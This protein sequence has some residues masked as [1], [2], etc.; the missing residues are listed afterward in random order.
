MT[1]PSDLIFALDTGTRTVTGLV[2]DDSGP[3]PVVLGAVTE[4][5][6]SRAMMDGQIHDI[7]AVAAV[8][9]T[10]KE[11]LER[12]V[13]VTLEEAAVAA[14]GRS[15]LTRR[16]TL[17]A[18]VHTLGE[19]EAEDVRRWEL[20]AVQAAQGQLR[21]EATERGELPADHPEDVYHCVGY[22]VVAYELDGSRI[23]N[24]VGHRGRQISIEVLATFLPEV[25]VD[26]LYTV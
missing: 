5:H 24:L 13:G 16:A 6:R 23:K 4:E 11:K 17:T 3:V 8:V 7:E 9:R 26:S 22:A 15:L 21:Q 12:Q 20:E 25:V 14:A 2:M 18:E 19:I 1:N 10:V